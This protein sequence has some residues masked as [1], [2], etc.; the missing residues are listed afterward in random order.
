M[1]RMIR[2]GGAVIACVGLSSA[3]LGANRYGVRVL[4]SYRQYWTVLPV[5]LLLLPRLPT[6]TCHV[7]S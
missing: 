3:I 6:G 7:A 1:K 5:G 2:V 4:M